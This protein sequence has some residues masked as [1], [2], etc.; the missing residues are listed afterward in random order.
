MPN[1][2]KGDPRPKSTP[3]PK[4]IEKRIRRKLAHIGAV[5]HMNRPGTSAY[6]VHGAINVTIPAT[7]EVLFSGMSLVQIAV[8]L[9][10]VGS[11]EVRH[12]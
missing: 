4:A 2:L 7:G 3:T 6:R 12:V 11:E 5:L 9:G 8:A 10:V 1:T